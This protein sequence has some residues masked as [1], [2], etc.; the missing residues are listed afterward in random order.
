MAES[1][2]QSMEKRYLEK[3]ASRAESGMLRMLREKAH[4]GSYL[5]I[6][7]TYDE[8]CTFYIIFKPNKLFSV[9]VKDRVIKKTKTH[10]TTLS[11]LAAKTERN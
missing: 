1:W 4:L 10:L 5:L 7:S 9:D 3:S 8:T 2:I 6:P 11:R